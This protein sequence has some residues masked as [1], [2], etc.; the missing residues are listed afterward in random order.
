MVDMYGGDYDASGMPVVPPAY[1]DPM[2]ITV[3]AELESGRDDDKKITKKFE[4]AGILKEDYGKGEETVM[5]LVMSLSDLK[6]LLEQQARISGKKVERNKGYTNAVVKVQDIKNVA[7]VERQIKKMGFRTSSMESIRKPMERD[8]RQKQMM[9]AGIGAVSLF[10]AALGITNTMIMSISERTREIGVMKSLGCFV[11]DI[12]KIFL[13]EAGCIGFA[14]G[15]AG[16]VLSFGISALMNLAAGQAAMSSEFG[17]FGGEMMEQTSGLSI[18]PWWLAVFA[19]LFS[20]LIGIGAGYY[21][22]SKAVEIPA[23]EAIKHE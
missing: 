5:G 4:T 1:F 9:F 17:G 19:I 20:V 6:D 22:A 18:I 10:V 11:R 14:G 12:R 2:K 7:E 3:T 15:L 23:L 8:A 21:P 13:M 16:V